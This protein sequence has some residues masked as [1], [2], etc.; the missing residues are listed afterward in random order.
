MR[1]RPGA[2][3]MS[4]LPDLHAEVCRNRLDLLGAQIG[5]VERGDLGLGRAKLKNRL[6]LVRSGADFH[7]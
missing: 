1:L 7:K 5:I 2:G 3:F 4:R 6:F